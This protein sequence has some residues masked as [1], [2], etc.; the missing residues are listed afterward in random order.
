MHV[1]GR[2]TLILAIIVLFLGRYLTQRVALLTRYSIPEP[3]TGGIIASLVLTA[4]IAVGGVPI[5][6]DLGNRDV[7]LVAFFTTIGLSARVPLL[8]AGGTLLVVLTL[9][10]AAN[11]VLQNAIGVGLMSALGQP[12]A[13]GLLTGSAGLLGG[14]GTVAAWA[15]VLTERFGVTGAAELGAATATIGL[16][17]GG[18]LGGPLGEKLITRHQLSGQDAQTLAVGLPRVGEGSEKLDANAVLAS[19]LVIVVAMAIADVVNGRLAQ[20]GVVLPDF[21]ASLVVGIVLSN[22]IP[23]LWRRLPWPAGSPAMGLIAEVALGLFLAMS[24]MTMNLTTLRSTALPLVVVLAVQVLVSWLLLSHVVFRL[25][26]GSYD[27]A[28]TTGG[29][30]GLTMGATP[31]AIAIM[32]AIVKTHGASPRSFLVL[33]LVGAFFVDIINAIVLGAFVQWLG[34]P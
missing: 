4:T 16:I 17:V 9:V 14:H 19:L 10:A 13:Y 7:L 20:A 33:P 21:V 3:V 6:F 11:I 25:L 2:H 34:P 8:L 30:F 27:A 1:D 31:T 22:S 28:V 23:Y 18:V 15:P 12:A 32:T 26:G 24:L 29:Y 5:T